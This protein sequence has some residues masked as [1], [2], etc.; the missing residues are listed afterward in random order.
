MAHTQK[1]TSWIREGQIA[2]VGGGLYGFSHTVSGHP[3]DNIKATMQLDPRYRGQSTF[4]VARGMW[5]EHGVRAF[6]RGCVPPL[7]GSVVYRSAMMSSYEASYTFLESTAKDSPLHAELFGVRPL[8]VV[9]AVFCSCF[10][11]IFES[12]IEYAKV[13]RQTG[14][15]WVLRDVYRGAS[16]QVAR[17][18]AMLV[19]IFVPYD[20]CRRYTTWFHSL[21]TQWF[22]TTLV[23]GGSYAVAWPLE[24][25][26]NLAQ[27]GQPWPGASVMERVTSLGGFRGL[28]T[29]AGPGIVCGGFRNGV[30]MLA[31]AKYHQYATRW[32]L[33]D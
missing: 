8:V 15:A 24:T 29:G 3:L 6:F 11:A 31:M 19:L 1:R 27:A 26:K 30:A 32:G 7:W 28:Y 21:P 12:P 18:T 5:Q 20:V 4:D 33:R 9:S 25:L 2:I 16:T 17:T 13:M 22:V 14:R 23:C 10:R